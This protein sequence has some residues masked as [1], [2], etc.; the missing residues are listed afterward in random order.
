MDNA[1]YEGMGGDN[2]PS[3]MVAQPPRT[4]SVP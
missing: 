2:G 4:G 1:G 3:G